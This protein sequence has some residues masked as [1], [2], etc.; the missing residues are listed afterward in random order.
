MVS[1]VG[2]KKWGIV[3]EQRDEQT[4]GFFIKKIREVAKNIGFDVDEPRFK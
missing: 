1:T 2:L 4:A 3:F